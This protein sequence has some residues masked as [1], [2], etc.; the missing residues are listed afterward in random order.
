[1]KYVEMENQMARYFHMYQQSQIHQGQYCQDMEL[2]IWLSPAYHV[3]EDE[4]EGNMS[5]DTYTY[6]IYYE[7]ETE[8]YLCELLQKRAEAKFAE[9]GHGVSITDF[10]W[11]TIQ[12]MKPWEYKGK[13]PFKELAGYTSI[14][15]KKSINAQEYLYIRNVQNMF[16]ERRLHEVDELLS[17]CEDAMLSIECLQIKDVFGKTNIMNALEKCLKKEKENHHCYIFL[18]ITGM[19]VIEIDE[20]GLWAEGLFSVEIFQTDAFSEDKETWKLKRQMGLVNT[21]FRKENGKWKI[22]QMEISNLIALPDVPYRNDGRFDK[23]GQTEE[24]WDIHQ[25]IGAETSLDIAFAVENMINRWVYASRHGTLPDFVE[26]YM[27]N[28]DNLNYMKM[29][30]FGDR[31]KEQKDLSEILEK[32]SEMN[33]HFRNR[34][35]T[36]HAPTTPVI[37]L[38]KEGDFAVGTWF[39]HASTNLREMVKSPEQIPYMVFVN[40]YVHK[41]KKMNG[42]W[43]FTRFYCEPL[44]SL[45]DWELDMLHNR[46][47]IS[48][49]DTAHFPDVFELE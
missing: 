4:K 21:K 48:Q 38:N 24:P 30:S 5:C 20:S 25:P 33:S 43:Y 31:S 23:M 16:F 2:S 47:F 14:P 41:F 6:H 45:P 37:T 28:P 40:K 32:V 12:A 44:I 46:G 42:K 35:Y 9:N 3:S 13:N 18:G 7:K 39:D 15:Q 19:P 22:Y 29:R 49:P 10:E 26:T 36:Y 11:Y 1:M 17:D 34:Y 8:K 27:R